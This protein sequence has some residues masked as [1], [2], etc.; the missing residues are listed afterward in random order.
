MNA[1]MHGGPMHG[2]VLLAAGASSRLGQSKQLLEIDGEPLLRR[3][4]RALLASEPLELVVVLGHEA[5]R[6]GAV[7]DGL[8]LRRVVAT[9]HAEGMAA[10]LRTGIAALDPRCDGALVALTDQPALDGAHLVALCEAWRKA[11]ARAVASRYA[12]LAGAPA[13]LPRAW[14]DDLLALRGDT[15]ARALLRARSDAVILLD[16]PALGRD[17][18][19]PGQL[20]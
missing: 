7:L 12:G 9:G 18:D 19:E 3:A 20:P 4:A 6:I 10:A 2:A 1:P 17:I 16:A 8:P 14:F 11:P 15:G 5:P 13:M